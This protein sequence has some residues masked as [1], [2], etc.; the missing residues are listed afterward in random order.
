MTT[1]LEV[2]DADGLDAMSLERLADE[3]G[4]K[5][6]SL[7]HHFHDKAEILAAVRGPCSSRRHCHLA[8]TTSRGS[9][10]SSR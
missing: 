5:A 6:P 3:L 1:A 2:I 10:G 9:S 8:A 7:Y 4:V